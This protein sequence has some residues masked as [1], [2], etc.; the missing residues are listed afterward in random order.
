MRCIAV[1]FLD[2]STVYALADAP[3]MAKVGKKPHTEYNISVSLRGSSASWVV[4][5]RWSAFEALEADLIKHL[6]RAGAADELPRLRKG[7]ERAVSSSIRN[8]RTNAK[9]DPALVEVRLAMGGN[10]F[11]TPLFVW[12]GESPMKDTGAC[13]L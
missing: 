4:K 6:K 3:G 9:L 8:F 7:D 2:T 11:H 1:Q 13:K 12:H 10:H 5:S